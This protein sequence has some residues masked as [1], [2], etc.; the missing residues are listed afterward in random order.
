ML[1]QK[2]ALFDS[3]SCGDNI[4]FPLRETTALSEKEIQEKVFQPDFTMKPGTG[5]GLGL[6]IVRHISEL[7]KGHVLLDS[8]LGAGTLIQVKIP[9]FSNEGA[10]DGV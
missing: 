4:A 3:L 2:N 5:T 6:A 8:N 7:R 9:V 10:Y 1:F